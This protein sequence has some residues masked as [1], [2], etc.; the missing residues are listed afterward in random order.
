[1]EQSRTDQLLACIRRELEEQRPSLDA[2]APLTSVS[3]FVQLHP[4][5]NVRRVQFRADRQRE[6][7]GAG[8]RAMLGDHRGDPI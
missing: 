8:R 7:R 4:D 3:V 6:I 2:G 5:G 1:M